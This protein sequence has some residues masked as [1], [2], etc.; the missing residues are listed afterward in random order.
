MAAQQSPSPL[1]RWKRLFPVFSTIDAA[2]V[3]SAPGGQISDDV[4]VLRK[5]TRDVVQDL[6][7]VP[8]DDAAEDLCR[9][10][11]D[12]MVEYLIT[13][14]GAVRVTVT[15]PS[16]GK[17]LGSLEDL[18]ESKRVR[19]LARFVRI[20]IAKART[21]LEIEKPD[22]REKR[23][24]VKDAPSRTTRRVEGPGPAREIPAPAWLPKKGAPVDAAPVAPARRLITSTSRPSRPRRRRALLG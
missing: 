24:Q 18:H 22:G 3:A 7:D 10:L 20:S 2:I 12:V 16:L 11:D 15:T 9:L 21:R 13:L 17:A 19:E 5:A 4:T 6:C 14:K 8:E 1:R 23:M